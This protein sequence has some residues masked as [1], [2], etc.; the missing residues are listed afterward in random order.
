MP[1]SHLARSLVVQEGSFQPVPDRQNAVMQ[2]ATGGDETDLEV[3]PAYNAEWF[4]QPIQRTPWNLS[5]PAH[6]R[7]AQGSTETRVSAACRSVPLC[8]LAGR[9]MHGH[10][11]H[12]MLSRDPREIQHVA[13]D[14]ALLSYDHSATESCSGP[15][16][17]RA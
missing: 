2:V 14:H 7:C 10:R 11:D 3:C 4:A 1:V 17:R 8:A 15:I 16:R 9:V 5:P 12:P 6:M 13:T